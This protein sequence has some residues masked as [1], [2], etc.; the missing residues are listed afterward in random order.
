MNS[1]QVTSLLVE[2]L[3]PSDGKKNN[4][5]EEVMAEQEGPRAA[6]LPATPSQPWA[7]LAACPQPGMS[8]SWGQCD[9]AAEQKGMWNSYVS[10]LGF[11]PDS[12]G[13]EQCLE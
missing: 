7:G 10:V 6:W 3:Q 8:L 13:Q 12:V 5:Q 2:A 11:C 1:V 9:S 4:T